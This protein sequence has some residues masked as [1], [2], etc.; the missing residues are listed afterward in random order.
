MAIAAILLVAFLLRVHHIGMHE[1]WLDETFS[2]Q[3]A[4]AVHWARDLRLR[5][6]PPLYTVLLHFW[7]A[8]AGTDEG[9]LRLL[10]ALLG[11]LAVGATMWLAREM[12]EPRAVVPAGV[13]A[14]LAPMSL[15]RRQA[16]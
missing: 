3:D 16:R 7:T 2:F 9:A 11:T 12:G 8:V 5:D 10:S 15:G 1:F 6:M 13:V 4:T 14:A